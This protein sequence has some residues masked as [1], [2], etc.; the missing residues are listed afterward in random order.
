M[1]CTGVAFA[2]WAETGA[3]PAEQQQSAPPNAPPAAQ[4]NPT[5]APAA[6]PAVTDVQSCLQETGDYV[7]HGNAITYVIG[8]TNSCD[9]RVRCKISAYVVGAKGPASGQT[10]MILGAQSSGAAANKSYAMKVKAAGGTAQ[11]SRDCQ[12][13]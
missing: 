11:V 3:A 5:P 10:T 2:A 9:K 8:L 6:A 4:Q 12:F 13:L 7:T 1:L